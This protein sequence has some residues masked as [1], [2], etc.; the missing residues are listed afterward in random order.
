[1]EDFRVDVVVGK[2]PGATAIPLDIAPFTLVGATTR[3]GLLPAPLRDRFG[4][5]AHLDFYEPGE[6]EIIVR[7]S[8]GLLGVPLHEDGGAEIA[9]RSR[10][11]PQ[12]REQAAAPRPRLRGGPRRRRGERSRPHA[13]R[14]NCTRWT[15]RVSTGST[16]RF[17]THC[18]GGSTAGPS[19]CPRW[20]SR[21][22]RN[23]RPS[24][25]WPSPSW[26]GPGCW[27]GR[28]GG[29][30]RPRP[31]GHT[32]AF[33]PRPAARRRAVAAGRG[34]AADPVLFDLTQANADGLPPD[35]TQLQ[36]VTVHALPTA[37]PHG[38]RQ[39]EPLASR[40][41]GGTGSF[42]VRFWQKAPGSRGTGSRI[43]RHLAHRCAPGPLRSRARHNWAGEAVACWS[44]PHPS[45]NSDSWSP[46]V[47]GATPLAT[48]RV[49]ACIEP[50]GRMPRRWATHCWR[51]RRRKA[52]RRSP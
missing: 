7:R 35:G 22:A 46:A 19:A 13:P 8:A 25:W 10:G 18:S 21:S 43:P 28:R 32:S 20:P 2:G 34:A 40:A 24:R 27:P 4:F 45:L 39:H 12:D 36:R 52:A 16:R 31:R 44:D 5:T 33:P 1:M 23:R 26:S 6:L 14:L 3:A 42:R 41:V 48:G 29:G 37:L 11:T 47:P 15:R 49:T 50:T 51:P 30:S 9:R 38:P 17:S